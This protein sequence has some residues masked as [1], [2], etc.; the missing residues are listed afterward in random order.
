M[1][2]SL[3]TGGFLP[4]AIAV[5]MCG[6]GLHLTLTDFK[7]VMVFP[8][9]I[10]IGLVNLALV[11]PVLAFLTAKFFGLPAGLAI[12]L[13][14][15]GASPGGAMANML[16]HWARGD[17][18]LSVSMTAIS[19]VGAVLTVPLFLGL[20]ESHFG[21]GLSTEISMP[22]IVGKVFA[23]TILPVALGMWLQHRY[24][25]WADRNEA[26]IGRLT[27]GLFVLL[28]VAVLISEGQTIL[29][30]AT[31]VAA[32]CLALNLSAMAISFGIAKLSRLQDRQATS[33]AMELGLH[34]A[35]L[36]I[37]V[38]AA[39][40]TELTIPAAVYSGFMF[41]TGG[42]FAAFMRRRNESAA[43]RSGGDHGGVTGGGID[44][45][46]LAD[47]EARDPGDLVADSDNRQQ[48]PM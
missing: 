25:E 1:E 43:D 33:I 6:L 44:L 40:D 4:A 10:L 16:T 42:A 19:S 29:E 28:I 48:T 24:P 17:T 7:R 12:G 27:L 46:S 30:H 11:A 41:V 31:E 39:I 9:G 2:E 32:A 36:A 8:R 23:I 47:R 5:I 22:G 18:A 38:G 3:L 14:L 35:A 13:V 26:R 45:E 37:A 15:L 20:A 21:G 34:N